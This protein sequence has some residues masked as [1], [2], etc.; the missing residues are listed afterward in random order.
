MRKAIQLALAAATL[1]AVS[2]SYDEEVE[3][4][5]VTVRLVYPAKSDIKP[6]AGARVE[7]KNAAASVFVEL[8]DTAGVARFMLPSGL[9][10]ATSASRLDTLN[11]RYII[12]GV[13]GKTAIS[14]DSINALDMKMSVTKRRKTQ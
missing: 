14:K 1:L 10:E 8:T 12:N 13:L 11:A 2:C 9:Y 6:Y 5:P 7:M 3:L 4:V